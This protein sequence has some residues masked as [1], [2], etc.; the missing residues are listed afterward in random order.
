MKVV[1]IGLV[2]PITFDYLIQTWKFDQVRKSNL[3]IILKSHRKVKLWRSCLIT[4]IMTVG[5]VNYVCIILC[6]QV[7]WTVNKM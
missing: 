7:S 5:I 3:Q 6:I 2:N 1:V 4:V